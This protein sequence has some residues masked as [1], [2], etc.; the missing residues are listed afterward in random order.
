[1]I[2]IS[3]MEEEEEE[4]E[5]RGGGGGGGSSSSSSNEKYFRANFTDWKSAK[6]WDGLPTSMKRQFFRVFGISD[7]CAGQYKGRKRFKRLSEFK[8]RF[9]IDAVIFFAATAHFKGFHD[10]L[11]KLISRIN[12]DFEKTEKTRTETTWQLLKFIEK[13]IAR[14]VVHVGKGLQAVSRYHTRY[15]TCDWGDYLEKSQDKE[16]GDHAVYIDRS[17]SATYDCHP[18]NDTHNTYMVASLDEDDADHL[19]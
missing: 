18:L 9:G 7:G 11:G 14:E 2:I 19:M 5:E 13:Y 10:A 1:M 8:R 12:L 3:K 15:L 17:A 6:V 4:E 16:Y